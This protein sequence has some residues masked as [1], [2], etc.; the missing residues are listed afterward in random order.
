MKGDGEVKRLPRSFLGKV[1]R[2]VRGK[3][4]ILFE[5]WASESGIPEMESGSIAYW[6]CDLRKGT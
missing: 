5:R 6:M 3:Y 4:H 2:V 1:E